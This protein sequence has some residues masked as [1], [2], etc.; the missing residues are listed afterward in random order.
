MIEETEYATEIMILQ[1]KF[2]AFFFHISPFFMLPIFYF[3]NVFKHIRSIS[4]AEK[5]Y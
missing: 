2:H 5:K 3:S 4:V 1:D